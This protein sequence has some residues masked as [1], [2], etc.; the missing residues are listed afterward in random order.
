M[1]VSSEYL[2]QVELLVDVL[3]IVAREPKFALKGGTAINLFYKDM[4]RLSVDIDLTWLPVTDRSSSLKQITAA[5]DRIAAVI[6]NS[7]PPIRVQHIKSRRIGLPEI[8]VERNEKKI[9]IETSPVARGTVL[10]PQIMATSKT[11]SE[12][13]RSIT[14]NVASFEDV[15][16][17]KMCAALGRKH[18]RDLFDIKVLYDDNDR[19]TDNLFRVFMV[20]VASSSRPLHEQLSPSEPV[21]EDWY[22]EQFQGMALQKISLEILIETGR[23][24][25]N[26][27]I[28]RLTGSVATFLTSLHDAEPDFGLIG[29]PEVEKLPAVRWKLYNLERLK[30]ENPKK[31]AEQRK[32]LEQLYR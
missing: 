6:S 10:P 30:R 12:K 16:A 1:N 7:V 5:F 14:M 28:S 11:V 2:D 13:F 23:R 31:H 9:K 22:N 19:I 21:R 18:P 27:I 15:Y 17:G 4:P 20:Y 24:L 3:P 8:V 26:D 29:L 25:H 32:A